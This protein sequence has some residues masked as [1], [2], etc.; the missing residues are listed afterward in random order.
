MSAICRP[1]QST[2]LIT[3]RPTQP[4]TT[5]ATTHYEPETTTTQDY[6]TTHYE[7]ETTTTQDYY[8][9]HYEPET[10][11]TQD[12]YTTHYEPETT[13]TQDYYTTHY[14]PE[15]TT[16]Q[17]YY[18]T[19]YEPETTTTVV[20]YE[21]DCMFYIDF[22]HRLDNKDKYLVV[23]EDDLLA[24]IDITMRQTNS[25]LRC[26]LPRDF[27]MNVTFETKD[28]TAISGEDYLIDYHVNITTVTF[29]SQTL[30]HSIPVHLIADGIM[31]PYEFFTIKIG[32]IES[33]NDHIKYSQNLDEFV[34]Y[35]K[36]GA[37]DCKFNF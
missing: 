17:D 26:R 27:A 4:T 7:P 33:L 20:E 10:T 19:H 3:F 12:Y 30:T 14:E 28:Y 23:N 36:D 31:E 37:E 8:T 2:G 6:Y 35:I 9:T 13:T 34:V 21:D 11:T 22:A 5:E 24:H 15:T 32:Q 1:E 16:T 18:T 25:Q 29:N